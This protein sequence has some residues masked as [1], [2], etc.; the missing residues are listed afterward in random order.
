M[1]RG[2]LTV[3]GKDA[4]AKEGDSDGHDDGALTEMRV[5]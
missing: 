4:G 1:R 5:A 2:Q 3:L